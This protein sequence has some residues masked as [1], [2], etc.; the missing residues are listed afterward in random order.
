MHL[1]MEMMKKGN[2]CILS[3]LPIHSIS[4]N[5]STQTPSTGVGTQIHP[6]KEEKMAWRHCWKR[7]AED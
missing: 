2:D 5:V 3:L 7:T 4:T 6:W 1:K